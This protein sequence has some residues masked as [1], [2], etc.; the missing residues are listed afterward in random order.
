MKK[1]DIWITLNTEKGKSSLELAEKKYN[2]SQ[3]GARN[4]VKK[5][6]K[7]INFNGH[8]AFKVL[9]TLGESKQIIYMP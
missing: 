6:F 5:E 8:F 3:P 2:E 9:E 4:R 7:A 1:S